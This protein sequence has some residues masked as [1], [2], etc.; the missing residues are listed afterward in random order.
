[1]W[2]NYILKSNSCNKTYNGSTNN[3]KRRIRQHN[4]IIK[5]GAKATQIGRPYEIYCLIIG[6]NNNIDTLK[7]EWRIKHPTK[8]RKR[9][10]KYCNPE[11][12]IKGLNYLLQD[13]KF[14]NSSIDI[15]DTNLTIIIKNEYLDLLKDISN[16][17]KIISVN[18]INIDIINNIDNL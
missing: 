3:I 15:C 14:T 8:T 2:C 11:G 13:T 17:F 9:P 16:K 10:Y 4:G 1:M 5:G 18:E 7:C 12:R 6:F